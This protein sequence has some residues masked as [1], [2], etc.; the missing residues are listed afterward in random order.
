[1]LKVEV[2]ND[3]GIELLAAG[4][5]I[6]LTSD[7]GVTIKAIYEQLKGERAKEFF[8]DGLKSFL[9]EGLY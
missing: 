1:M 9:D 2:G 6:E 4:N 3:C 5:V 8:I 7:V